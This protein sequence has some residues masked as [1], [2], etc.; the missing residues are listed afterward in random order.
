VAESCDALTDGQ[1]RAWL[2]LAAHW[3]GVSGATRDLRF[4]NAAFKLLGAVHASRASESRSVSSEVRLVAQL[5]A[6]AT[7]ELC[8]HLASHFQAA[9]GPEVSASDWLPVRQP[10]ATFAARPPRIVLLA[11]LGSDTAGRL[12]IMADAVGVRL[13]ALCWF[14]PPRH[15]Q[16][17]SSYDDAWY[18]A[19]YP[20]QATSPALAV[21]IAQARADSWD[22]VSDILLEHDTDLVILAGMPIVPAGVLGL[23][24]EI[25]VNLG[26]SPLPRWLGEVT[27]RGHVAVLQTNADENDTADAARVLDSFCG[28]GLAEAVV[29]TV[30]RAGALCRTN[31]G[32]TLT[33]TAR[34]VNVRQVQDAGAA[35]SAAFIHSRH[36]GADLEQALRFACAAGSLW[37]GRTHHGPLPRDDEITTFADSG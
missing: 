22:R 12:A 20:P 11:G 24:R 37:C 28:L 2:S 19:A 4:F 31:A 13:A 30:G 15:D 18:P 26:G 9:C 14:A 29:V 16:Q 8:G 23:A 10:A 17:A 34:A 1:A 5:T 36:D 25:V 33:A 35:F 21:P 6:T 32:E 27:R 7:S 3:I